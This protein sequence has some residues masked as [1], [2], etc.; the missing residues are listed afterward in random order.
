M[1]TT[2][3]GKVEENERKCEWFFTEGE[4]CH[5]GFEMGLEQTLS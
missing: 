1:T 5:G 3:A 2:A 4:S